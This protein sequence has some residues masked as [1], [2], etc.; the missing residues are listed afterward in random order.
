MD[1]GREF[2]RSRNRGLADV[3]LDELFGAGGR[4]VDLGRHTYADGVDGGVDGVD[5]ADPFERSDPADAPRPPREP[6]RSER[7]ASLLARGAR[8]ARWRI[9][10]ERRGAVAV[11][12]AVL[13]AVLAVGWQALAGRPHA[14][15]VANSTTSSTAWNTASAQAGTPASSGSGSGSTG[16][17]SSSAEAPGAT[18]PV[19]AAKVVVDVV[20]RVHRPG[21][22][23]LPAGAR[24]ADAV[25]AAGGVLAG[26]NLSSTNLARICVD[27]E[28]IAIGVPGAAAAPGAP[29]TSGAETPAALVNLN[30]ATSDQLD[31]LPGVGPVMAQRII[32][33]RTDH[34]PFQSVDQLRQVS[35]IG[36]VKYADLSPLVTV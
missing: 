13:V 21:L 34:G 6:G 7:N 29:G 22:V 5:E 30:T 26:T 31:A 20:G 33:Y 11:M 32:E 9:D 3:R 10:P 8:I 27:G 23:T 2:V 14:E 18:V 15:A 36:D 1:G 28:Q 25:R 35:G 12:G 4:P 16:G 17:V 19:A 24:V